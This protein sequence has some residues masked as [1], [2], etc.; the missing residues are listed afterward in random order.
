[1]VC[2]KIKTGSCVSHQGYDGTASMSG[3]FGV[4]PA[5]LR[6]HMPHATYVHCLEHTL[7]LFFAT[8]VRLQSLE[9]AL[10][11]SFELKALEKMQLC[12]SH[13]KL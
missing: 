11:S 7:Y 4:A 12:T 8:C 6:Q 9:T 2:T 13:R 10:P 5:C 3:E 1:M